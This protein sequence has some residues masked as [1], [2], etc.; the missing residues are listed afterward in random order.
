MEQTQGIK[1]LYQDFT[2]LVDGKNAFPEILSC[3]D[4]AERSV[5]INMF[6]WRDDTIGNRLAETVLRAANRGVQVDISVDR[7]GVVLEKSEEVKKSF[8]HKTQS[9]TEKIKI[10]ALELFYPMPNAPRKAKDESSALY[11][12]IQ[13]H[14]NITIEADEFTADHSKY[15]IIDEKIL[16]L[17]GVNIEDKE[18]GADMQGRAYQDYMIKLCGEKYV[19][20]FEKKLLTGENLSTEYFFG[21]NVKKPIRRFEMEK[22][23][24]DMI[25]NTKEK[26]YITMAYFS[27][28]KAFVNAIV[29][30][31]KRGVNVTIMIPKNANY[32]SDS[33]KKTVKKL[34]KLTGNKIRLYFSPKMLHTKMVVTD[35]WISFGSTNITK[36]AFQQLNEL[37]I[38]IENSD[39]TIKEQLFDSM[40]E[41]YA[42]SEKIETYSQ[43]K[44]NA[45][46]AFIE[47][48]LV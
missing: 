19:R 33:N 17:G 18:N 40:Q 15:Y 41:N 38:F 31:V 30:A 44:Y 25:E 2:L 48:F 5:K 27:P 13:R 36:K 45:F 22:L 28:L 7:Y 34:M 6:I 11:E 10:R 32:Q 35:E 12:E 3:I 29:A 42:F 23:Y 16:I 14:P 24:L 4:N 1:T 26:L 20:D 9:W 43:I 46:L 47:G 21:I 37:N 8:F 39:S